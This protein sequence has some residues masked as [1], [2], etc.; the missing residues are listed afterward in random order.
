MAQQESV[1]GK[2]TAEGDRDDN[3]RPHTIDNAM[4]ISEAY[5]VTDHSGTFLEHPWINQRFSIPVMASPYLEVVD[6]MP[7]PHFQTMQR[8]IAE[9]ASRHCRD[10]MPKDLADLAG[11]Y[12]GALPPWFT[13]AIDGVI[14]LKHIEPYPASG[15]VTVQLRTLPISI[16]GRFLIYR[17]CDKKAIYAQDCITRHE[18]DQFASMTQSRR[19]IVMLFICAAANTRIV[20]ID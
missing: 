20:I 19:E 10:H 18:I 9:V 12:V 1:L 7:Y 11:S 14:A 6:C 5:I 3:K 16:Y 15:V 8:R 4:D 13:T 2:R 17:R